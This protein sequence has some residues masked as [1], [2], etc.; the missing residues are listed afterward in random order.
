M[1]YFF[2][3]VVGLFGYDFDGYVGIVLD[4]AVADGARCNV[5]ERNVKF[6]TDDSAFF[7]QQYFAVAVCAVRTHDDVV[8]I[9]H[10]LNGRIDVDAHERG[11]TLRLG[12]VGM[13]CVD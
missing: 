8:L 12:G 13:T 7:K 10:K 1:A 11:R 9:E 3:N 4:V 5:A 2:K 6:C